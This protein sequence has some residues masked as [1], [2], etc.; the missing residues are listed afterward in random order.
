MVKR[1]TLLFVLTEMKKNLKLSRKDAMMP[2]TPPLLLSTE[3][4]VKRLK[5]SPI[6]FNIF[7]NAK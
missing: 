6:I 4:C 5:K 1:K 7:L 2:S 3:G